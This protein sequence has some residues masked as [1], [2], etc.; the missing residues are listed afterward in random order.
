MGTV[1]D[2][3]CA[4]WGL[5]AGLF[6]FE[7]QGRLEVGDMGP[8]CSHQPQGDTDPPTRLRESREPVSALC[9]GLSEVRAR[10]LHT[11]HMLSAS[12]GLRVLSRLHPTLLS[13]P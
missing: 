11:T 8:W 13:P 2:G 10:V 12:V 9:R 7:T 4:F 6:P 1:R 5:L 3:A